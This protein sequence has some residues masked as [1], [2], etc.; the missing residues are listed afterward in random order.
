MVKK[1]VFSDVQ[2]TGNLHIGTT[3]FRAVL[4]EVGMSQIKIWPNS[5]GD[6][7][8]VPFNPDKIEQAIYKALVDTEEGDR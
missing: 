2:P 3:D 1:R 5:Q 4:G 7:C 8:L 6:G